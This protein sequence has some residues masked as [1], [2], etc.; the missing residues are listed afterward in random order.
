MEFSRKKLPR[1]AAEKMR[2][3]PIHQL[4]PYV[5]MPAPVYAFLNLNEKFVSV[6]APLDFFI[7]DELEQ[8]AS[9]HQVYFPEFVDTLEPFKSA[10]RGVRKFLSLTQNSRSELIPAAYELADAVLKI[11]GPL[12]S[13]HGEIEPFFIVI[14]ANELL[15]PLSSQVLVEARDRS[16]E[17]F[18]DAI[19]I[20]SWAIFLALHLGYTDLLFLESLRSRIFKDVSTGKS[21]FSEYV[22]LDE[23]YSEALRIVK[24]R[25]DRVV[26]GDVFSFM[27]GRIA[28]KMASRMV[29][30]QEQF[31]K[32]NLKVATIF[33]EGGF[34]DVSI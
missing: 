9:L 17:L 16:V 26:R 11:I 18:E 7:P 4:Q 3:C 30:I 13:P 15:D 23:L 24:G 20:S 29:R 12:W 8:I 1:E 22:P 34:T 6:K 25:A 31:L 10:G 21:S 28:E 19:M 2:P 33:G 32:N 27:S 14:F 5:L